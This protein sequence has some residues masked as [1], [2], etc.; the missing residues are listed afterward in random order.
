VA[1]PL[2]FYE[3]QWTALVG[4]ALNLVL[5]SALEFGIGRESAPVGQPVVASV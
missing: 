5:L 3:Q 4:L 1:Q 2:A